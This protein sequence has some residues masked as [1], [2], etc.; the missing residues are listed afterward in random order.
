MPDATAS[1]PNCGYGFEGLRKSTRMFDCPSCNTT[2]FREGA[3][4]NPVGK[5]GEMHDVPMLMGLQDSVTIDGKRHTVVG[6]ARFDYGRG[7]WD[8]MYAETDGGD[9]IWISLDEGDVAVERQLSDAD[10]PRNE[11]MPAGGSVIDLHGE[12]FTVTES[13]EATCTAVRGQFPE[14]LEMGQTHRFLDASGK[15]GQLLS[16]EF[17]DGG[18]A[19]F[20]GEWLDPFVL[21]VEKFR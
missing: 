8:E 10:S 6:H 16:G 5:S 21:K 20:R 9:G 12:R 4:L 15:S 11:M 14:L 19:W 13:N 7:F 17:W 18:R 3:A 1:C 2:L